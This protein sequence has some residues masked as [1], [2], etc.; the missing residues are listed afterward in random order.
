[1][2]PIKQVV[3]A[4]IRDTDGRILLARRA[5]GQHLEGHWELP[6]GKVEPGESLESALQRELLEE[7]GLVVT[8]GEELARTEYDYDRGSIELI[9]LQTLA[10]GDITHMT[11]HDAFDWFAPDETKAIAIAPADIPLLGS[12]W[13][14]QQAIIG[15]PLRKEPKR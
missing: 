11:V 15:I 3:C 5:P 1:M 2:P 8:V 6:G 12:V 9:A 14:G 7:L 4:V 10:S 13:Y